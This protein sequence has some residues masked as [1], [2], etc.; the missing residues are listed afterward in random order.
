MH[1]LS[2][3][4]EALALIGQQA[5][6]H[7]ARRVTGVWLELGALSCIEESA[8]R[9]AFGSACR[10]TLAEGSMLHLAVRAAPAWCWHCGAAVEI[11]RH[12]A[13]CPRCGGHELQVSG[14]DSLR[15]RQLEL[16]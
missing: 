16:E 5:G 12:G 15:V 8:L 7:G 9:F 3:C 1:E 10:G 14:G 6:R 13:G 4:Y 11:S 2:L